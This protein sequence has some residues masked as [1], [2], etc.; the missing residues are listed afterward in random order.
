MSKKLVI[1]CRVLQ[2][3]RAAPVQSKQGKP[4]R[5]KTTQNLVSAP[6]QVTRM[7]SLTSNIDS[8]SFEV[9]TDMQGAT[10]HHEMTFSVLELWSQPRKT[11]TRANNTSNMRALT[12]HSVQLALILSLLCTY[13]STWALCLL[14][15]CCTCLPEPPAG[16]LWGQ[17]AIQQCCS[18]LS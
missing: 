4:A 8:D 17:K 10:A 9:A 16:L 6:A 12:L 5:T 7:P 15:S 1:V 11:G 18:S 3:L 13:L 2:G 14:L